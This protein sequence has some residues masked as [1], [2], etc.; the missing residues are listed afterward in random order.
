[1]C[2]VIMFVMIMHIASRSDHAPLSSWKRLDF[3][4][5]NVTFL[6][7][8]QWISIVVKIWCLWLLL[9]GS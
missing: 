9:Y 5:I 1:M 2:D 3:E 7:L 4:T 6:P 8:S